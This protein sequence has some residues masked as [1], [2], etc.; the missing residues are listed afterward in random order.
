VLAVWA[1]H[2]QSHERFLPTEAVNLP[3]SNVIRLE[4]SVRAPTS[5]LFFSLWRP[6]R[7]MY[8]GEEFMSRRENG[9]LRTGRRR[10]PS[11]YTVECATQFQYP[12]ER[13]NAGEPIDFPVPGVE[14]IARR[15]I[16]RAQLSPAEVYERNGDY[17]QIVEVLNAWLSD[18]RNFTYSTE[19]IAPRA[20]EDP[21]LMFL[22][23]TRKGHCEYFASALAGMCRSVGINAR[24][25]TG[26][27]ADE[28]DDSRDTYVVRES[29]AHAW[30]EAEI[31][32]GLW[33][34]YD[35]SPIAG[36]QAAQQARTV[37]DRIRRVLEAVEFAWIT[38]VVGFSADDSAAARPAS[39]RCSPGSTSSRGSR[40]SSARAS[41]ASPP[42]RSSWPCSPT[43]SPSPP[44]EAWADT[45]WC[46]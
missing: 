9:V 21:I 27:L 1:R 10:L 35:P 32:P 46:C 11:S 45:S 28:Y 3:H 34:T 40:G 33:R 18:P 20:G 29:N 25:V 24:V 26:F 5:M 7:L 36:L 44:R 41:L 4:F 16:E 30:I 8:D 14:A 23:R 37:G 13:F 12:A 42:A 38:S 22:E 6:L 15:A 43:S 31:S 2:E 19:M 39:H 17:A